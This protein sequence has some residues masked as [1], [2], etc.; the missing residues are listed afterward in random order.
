M[1]RTAETHYC[2]IRLAVN[3]DSIEPLMEN[4][5]RY[6]IHWNGWLTPTQFET[7]NA[8]RKSCVATQRFAPSD[9]VHKLRTDSATIWSWIVLSASVWLVSIGCHSETAPSISTV[10]KTSNSERPSD[11]SF[12]EPE[13]PMESMVPTEDVNILVDRFDKAILGYRRRIKENSTSRFHVWLSRLNSHLEAEPDNAGLLLQR[14]NTLFFL[15]RF[16]EAVADYDRMVK[17]R[18][19]KYAQ[20]HWR[21][22]LALYYAGR[23]S[24]A[25]EQFERFHAADS[26]DRECGIWHYFS[27][28]RLLGLEEAR[29]R[30]FDYAT[31][32]GILDACYRHVVGDLTEERLFEYARE[33]QD[34]SSP[35]L[36]NL[37]FAN[38][39]AGLNDLFE[40]RHDE[41]MEHLAQAA[42]NEWA[43]STDFTS[44]ARFMWQ[45]SLLNLRMKHE[46]RD[47]SSSGPTVSAPSWTEK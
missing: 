47:A 31:P 7:R 35:P 19:L 10:D 22:G 28:R 41:A 6:Q 3:S 20:R 39:Y 33:Q 13:T 2:T 25:A 37:F 32:D 42:D 43:R 9:D 44:G 27:N 36:M 1:T 8:V 23:Y 15:E 40:G 21:R 11:G 30:K 16:D 38:L 14:G 4:L 5:G 18:P 26:D 12:P 34:I 46:S 29:R 24:D 45:L 17:L